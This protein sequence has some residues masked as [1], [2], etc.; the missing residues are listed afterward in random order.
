MILRKVFLGSL[1]TVLFVLS[2]L[3]NGW[4][5]FNIN[6]TVSHLLEKH[7]RAEIG[8]AVDFRRLNFSFGS[9]NLAGVTVRLADAPYQVEVE[10]IRLGYSLSSI[11]KNGLKPKRTAEDITIFKPRVTLLYNPG[12]KSAS[13]FDYSL[14]LSE[15]SE[16]RYR[17]VMQDYDFIKRITITE[18]SVDIANKETGV[19]TPLASRIN[20]WAY[21]NDAELSWLRL[22]GHIL[23][24]DES[25]LVMYGQLNLA[26]GGIDF[27]NIELRDYDIGQEVESL[28]PGYVEKIAGTVSGELRVT[29]RFQPQ[30]GFDLT[31]TGA[32]KNGSMKV[33]SENLYFEDVHIDA[34][35][36][37]WNLL[38]VP[39]GKTVSDSR[40]RRHGGRPDGVARSPPSVRCGL[41]RLA[42]DRGVRH[43]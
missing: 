13:N 37:D 24:S 2:I 33:T 34:E 23:G 28:L 18:G 17:S 12:N 3:Y 26:R 35:I 31:G 43:A 5:L 40:Q 36:K 8:D 32:V 15:D 1:L 30:R 21:T 39:A 4:N 29:E 20:G 6:D 7:I 10:E 38:P 42:S 14:Q 9:L 11:L 22:A 19:V 25:N 27:V 16:A 41:H